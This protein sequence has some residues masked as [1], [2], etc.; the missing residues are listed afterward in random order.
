MTDRINELLQRVHSLLF[1]LP[2]PCDPPRYGCLK[3]S[4]PLR[5]PFCGTETSWQIIEHSQNT[6][7]NKDT[8]LKFIAMGIKKSKNLPQKRQLIETQS[9]EI[10]AKLFDII[11]NWTWSTVH[12]DKRKTKINLKCSALYMCSDC[13]SCLCIWLA[14]SGEC[15]MQNKCGGIWNGARCRSSTHT[16]S[17]T[18]NCSVKT[19]TNVYSEV[20]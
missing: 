18:S 13:V 6:Q 2:Q 17:S 9:K 5:H 15:R 7:K 8:F 4:K 1:F 20:I 19:M 10:T 11:F 12:I 14:Q 16:Q 3:W